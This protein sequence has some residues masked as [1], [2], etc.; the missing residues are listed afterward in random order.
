MKIKLCG[1]KER[2]SLNL[3]L[4]YNPDYIGFIF[5][6]KSHRYV[7]PT[8]V[9]SL[10]ENLSLPSHNSNSNND[11]STQ[12]HTQHR[13]KFIGVFVNPSLETL[14]ETIRIADLDGVQLCGS[15]PSE[16]LKS[17]KKTL[18][19]LI[20]WK[21]FRLK[22]IQTFQ[23]AQ[24]SYAHVLE[25]KH[26]L[27]AIL[28]DSYDPN[29]YGGTG[30]PLETSFLTDW[31][32]LKQNLVL[33][34]GITVEKLPYFFQKNVYALDVSSTLE[35]NHHQKDPV[36]ITHFMQTFNNLKISH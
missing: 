7:T 25:N 23:T 18:N 6:K 3:A 9:R 31:L 24:K 17:L 30:H 5:Y 36:K 10:K 14:I 28:L 27:N 35:N 1:F 32:T 4:T 34:G 26:I 11:N 8:Q 16:L 20:I 22:N 2:S 12:S 13:P 15:E 33:A 29:A 19:H 21:A